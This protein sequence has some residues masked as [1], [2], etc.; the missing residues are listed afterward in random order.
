MNY[1]DTAKNLLD[2]LLKPIPFMVRPMA[3]MQIE[4]QIFAVAKENGHDTVQDDDVIRG[5]IMAGS[6]RDNA[7]KMKAFL[8]EKGYDLTPYQDILA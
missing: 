4:K 3:K 7:E 2:E 8:T 5:Y 6:K 1:N